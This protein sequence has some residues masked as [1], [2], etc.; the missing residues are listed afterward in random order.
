L[1]VSALKVATPATAT[2][3]VIPPRVHGEV[4]A[5]VSVAP[6][7]VVTTLLLT[8]ST[9]ALKV[10]STVL[11]AA[12][13]VGGAVVKTI[14]VA[15]PASKVIAVLDA[16][17]KVLVTSVA[18]NVQ[19]APVLI[20]TAGNVA[21]PPTAVSVV[22]PV[23]AHVDEITITSVAPVPAIGMGTPLLSS[24]ETA[25]EGRTVPAVAVADGSGVKPTLLAVVVA[26][27][28]AAF[29]TVKPVSPPV[30]SVAVRVQLVPTVTAIPVKVAT[31]RTA[32][33]VNVPVRVHEEEI[34]MESLLP[35][36]AVTTLP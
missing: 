5:M 4:I 9:D 2:A 19:A 29:A 11:A 12:T 6:V 34:T 13:E 28:T 35:V 24:T 25:K 31:P 1:T 22:V 16:V 20:I 10:V 15:A 36:P 26:T 21:T 33:C 23:S 7:P 18:T 30:E 8:S 32:F 17:A 3:V 27:F 14:C